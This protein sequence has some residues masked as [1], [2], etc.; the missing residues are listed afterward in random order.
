VFLLWK[1]KAE[2]RE[3]KYDE[4]RAKSGHRRG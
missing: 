4:G 3:S 2:S 1:I